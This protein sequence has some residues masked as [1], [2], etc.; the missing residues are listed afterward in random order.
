MSS[1]TEGTCTHVGV[2]LGV[3]MRT[4]VRAEPRAVE[5]VPR[6]A[7][8]PQLVARV[9]PQPE[10]AT[11]AKRE[12]ASLPGRDGAQPA[13]PVVDEEVVVHQPELVRA[14]T[15]CETPATSQNETSTVK[16][17][18][19]SCSAELKPQKWNSPRR[20]EYL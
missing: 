7:V 1:D 8:E 4:R 3:G 20:C 14:F 6:A 12:L 16:S 10:D 19:T 2:Q 18:S 5:V 9:A 15:T 11:P 13:L 17:G